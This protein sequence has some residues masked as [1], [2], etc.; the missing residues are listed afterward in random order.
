M[1]KVCFHYSQIPF[2]LYL[3]LIQVYVWD[4]KTGLNYKSE[5]SITTLVIEISDHIG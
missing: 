4:K 3:Y 5:L 1:L 2:L